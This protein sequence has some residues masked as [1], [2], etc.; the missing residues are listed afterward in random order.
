MFNNTNTITNENSEITHINF[1]YKSPD[2]DM[3]SLMG[4]NPD[5][6]INIRYT[7]SSMR[8]LLEHNIVILDK[9]IEN[10][11]YI[12]NLI[13][14]GCGLVEIEMNISQSRKKLIEENIIKKYTDTLVDQC[15]DISFNDILSDDDYDHDYES[16]QDRL[17]MIHNLVKNNES[18]NGS[19]NNDNN[20]SNNESQSS[21]TDS[22]SSDIILDNKNTRLLIE[23]YLSTIS[24]CDSSENND[25]SSED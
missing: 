4:H 24:N 5:G 3:V 13:P 7:L 17:S 8:D 23:K 16:N 25:T 2:E 19:N 6:S 22:E 12:S 9:L 14:I 1:T 20:G 11:D 18:N 10:A 21:N 15:N